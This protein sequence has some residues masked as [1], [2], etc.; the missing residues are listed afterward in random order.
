MYCNNLRGNDHNVNDVR[1]KAK[2][3]KIEKREKYRKRNMEN[4][5]RDVF[6][7][8]FFDVFFSSKLQVIILHAKVI[9]IVM[10]KYESCQPLLPHNLISL[11][12]R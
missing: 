9:F 12:L 1:A 6:N 5:N 11:S 2:N 7:I 10:E 8:Y 4:L 3:N